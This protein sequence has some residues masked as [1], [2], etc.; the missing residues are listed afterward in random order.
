LS[1]NTDMI[2]LTS[3]H[4]RLYSSLKEGRRICEGYLDSS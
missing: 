1:T 3:F 4:R 2:L